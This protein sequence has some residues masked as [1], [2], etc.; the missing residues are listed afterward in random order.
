MVK[1]A[2]VIGYAR[3]GKSV[4]TL[5]KAMGYQVS[6]TDIE[7]IADK[8]E[9]EKA[10]FQVYDLGHPDFLVNEAWSLVVKNP[11]IKYQVPFIKKIS[12]KHQII[13][14][15]EVAL[16]YSPNLEIA[17]ITGTNGK[18]TTTSLLTEMLQSQ[19][20]DAYGAGNIGL[21]LSE[22]SLK[23]KDKPAKV[24]LE[25]AS[26]QLVA[27]PNFKPKVA[28]ILNLTPDHLDYFPDLMSYYQSKLRIYQNQDENDYFLLNLDDAT[29]VSLVKDLKAK[30]ITYSLTQK[31][32][33]YYQDH[34]VFFHDE[35][36]FETSSMKLVGKHNIANA[37]V[38]ALMAYLLKVDLKNIQSVITSF[39]GV[40]HRLE[41][42]TEIAGVKYYNDSKA[43]NVESQVIALNAFS[44]PVILLAGGYDKKTGFDLLKQHQA[45]IKSLIAFGETKQ[46]FKTIFP[47]TILVNDLNEA[48]NIAY[49]LAKTNDVVLFSPGCASFDQYA[50]F[51]ERGRHFKKI[52]ANLK[53][54]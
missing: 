26:F 38:A 21:P 19:F 12:E 13:N 4:S 24:A 31:A 15:I 2:L 32:D 43:T 49:K 41:Y 35:C 48:T 7:K 45:Q 8:V 50:N 52:V 30:I 47:D 22:I 51:E 34:Q 6:I 46:Q 37:M 28:T 18:T 36:L 1:K 17:A 27:V 29:V 20:S 16:T 10:G 54:D 23:V 53:K 3:S 9:L 39:L 11:G 33:L 40:E 5:L 44:K 14:E 25:I 42:V